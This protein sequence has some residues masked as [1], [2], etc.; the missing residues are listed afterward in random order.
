[1]IGMVTMD[2]AEVL[3]IM[4]ITISMALLVPILIPI[5]VIKIVVMPE[6]IL[7]RFML[8]KAVIVHQAQAQLEVLAHLAEIVGRLVVESRRFKRQQDSLKNRTSF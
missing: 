7:M 5:V 6:Q 8:L 2:G 1:M 4:D 3:V